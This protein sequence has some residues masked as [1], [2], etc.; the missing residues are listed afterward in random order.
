QLCLGI[1]TF[2]AN[3]VKVYPNPANSELFVEIS[4]NADG[5]IID[6]LGRVIIDINLLNGVNIVNINNLTNG[7]Y[8]LKIRFEDKKENTVKIIKYSD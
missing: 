8:Y 4:E 1:N 6:A 7:I 5:Q 3:N 2:V